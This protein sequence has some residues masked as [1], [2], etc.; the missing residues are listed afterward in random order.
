MGA[1]ENLSWSVAKRGLGQLPARPAARRRLAEVVSKAMRC[2][3]QDS[4]LGHS[5]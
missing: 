4:N 3:V 5:F 2:V 1:Q